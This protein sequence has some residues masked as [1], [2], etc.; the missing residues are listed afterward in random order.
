[1]DFG[2]YGSSFDM[3]SFDDFLLG[4]AIQP[5][6]FPE[7]TIKHRLNTLCNSTTKLVQHE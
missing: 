1:M 3:R 5:F 6:P 7:H 2:G 4:S